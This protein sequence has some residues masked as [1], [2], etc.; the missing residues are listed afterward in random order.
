M[1]Q[2]VAAAAG[3][4]G[5]TAIRALDLV[6]VGPGTTVLVDGG[7][8]GVGAVVVQVAL[9]RGARVIA[10]AGA[11]NQDYLREIGATPLRY[12]DGLAERV[13][14]IAPGGVDAVV[15]IAGKTPPAVLVGLVPAA[16]QVVTI[17]NFGAGEAGVQVTAGR[18]PRALEA[19]ETIGGLLAEGKLVIKV[20]TFPFARA[21]EAHR[22]SQGRH[23][24]GKLV[25]IPEG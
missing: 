12:G 18:S 22:I 9:A 3:V 6:G 5:K 14:E 16:S 8:G 4:A 21:T 2:A 20:Q 17:A 25:L 10:T 1:V 24:R 23:V 11:D 15:D 19:L 13:R 7:A